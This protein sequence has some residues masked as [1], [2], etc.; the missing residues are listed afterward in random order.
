MSVLLSA[1]VSQSLSA[2][3][4]VSHEMVMQ[5]SLWIDKIQSYEIQMSSV[6][7]KQVGGKTEGSKKGNFH[8]NKFLATATTNFM[9]TASTPPPPFLFRIK[10][11]HHKNH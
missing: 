4:N 8:T 2:E 7:N 10:M 3:T 6:R 5:C 1:S 11:K 9:A